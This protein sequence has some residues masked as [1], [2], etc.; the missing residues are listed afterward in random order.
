MDLPDQPDEPP[1][2]TTEILEI[3][4]TMKA[5]GNDHLTADI[6]LQIAT[7]THTMNRCLQLYYF[8]GFWKTSTIKITPKPNKTDYT[9]TS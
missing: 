7:I 9:K 1:F 3:F 8:P 5:A 6:C 4:K 2:T